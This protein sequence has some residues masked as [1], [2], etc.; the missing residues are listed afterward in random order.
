V[1]AAMHVAATSKLGLALGGALSALASIA[2]VFFGILLHTG[3]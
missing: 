1:A 3:N 2:A